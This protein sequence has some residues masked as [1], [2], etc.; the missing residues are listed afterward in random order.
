[1]SFSID[2][3][4]QQDPLHIITVLDRSGSMSGKEKNV[5]SS[6]NELLVRFRESDPT[7]IVSLYIFDHELDCVYENE[8]ISNVKDL[9]T[10]QYVVRGMTALND[11]IGS[12]IARNAEFKKV[13]FVV[14]TDGIENASKEYTTGGVKTLIEAKKDSGWDVTFIGTDLSTASTA[15]MSLARGFEVGD[16]MA[17]A[18]SSAGYS[19][20]VDSLYN[21]AASYTGTWTMPV[22]ENDEN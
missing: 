7:A 15:D 20:R 5:I 14:D 8:Q 3:E 12:V 4:Q 6:Y 19:A 18:S 17:F 13:F 10:K 11:A 22:P 2:L 9:T 16:M 1:M 21:K